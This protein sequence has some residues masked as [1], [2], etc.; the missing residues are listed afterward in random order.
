[1]NYIKLMHMCTKSSNTIVHRHSCTVIHLDV[2]M[3]T[4]MR[5]IDHSYTHTY[6]YY[7]LA[8]IY[9]HES[10]V[11]FYICIHTHYGQ[12]YIHIY[13]LMCT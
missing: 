11:R 2:H 3:Y 7:T 13:M 5:A 6:A 4:P 9:R 8:Y 12:V 1:M 10:C